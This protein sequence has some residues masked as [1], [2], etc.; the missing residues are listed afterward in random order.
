MGVKLTITPNDGINSRPIMVDFKEV[1]HT[2]TGGTYAIRVDD[3]GSVMLCI[4]LPQS[5]G[6]FDCSDVTLDFGSD[7]QALINARASARMLS[8]SDASIGQGIYQHTLDSE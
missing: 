7:K 3:D 1:Y 5:D 4:L 8:Q 2:E 6:A